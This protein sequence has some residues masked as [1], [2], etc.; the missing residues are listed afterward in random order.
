MDLWAEYR[1]IVYQDQA[2]DTANSL[3]KI[4]AV[5]TII[6]LSGRGESIG[7]ED[8]YCE[9]DP[10]TVDEWGIPVLR[11]NYNWSDHEY[12]QVKHMQTTFRNI[13]DE[14]GGT[15]L[16]DMPSKEE[17]YGISTPGEIIHEVG[18]TRMGDDPNKSVLNKYCQ[19][20]DV[21]NLFVADGGP[22]VSQPHKNTT[23]T[24][25]ALSMRTSEYITDQMN[26]GNI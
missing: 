13:I 24:L 16:W 21:D 3:R 11:F 18:T 19:A 26:K 8:N 1:I 14:M 2:A 15:P 23:W 9:I 4:I 20:H 5:I 7:F 22:F 6:G 17:G 12:N 25:L 10:N